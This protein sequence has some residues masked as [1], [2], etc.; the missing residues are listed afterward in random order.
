MVENEAWYLMETVRIKKDDFP[1]K[2]ALVLEPVPFRILGS[3]VL[4]LGVRV[5]GRTIVIRDMSST[6]GVAISTMTCRV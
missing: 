3:L 5:F 2:L 1:P 6:E 4:G